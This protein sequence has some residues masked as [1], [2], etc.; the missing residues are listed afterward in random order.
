MLKAILGFL[1]LATL[2][3]CLVLPVLHFQGRLDNQSYKNYLLAAS[4]A[5]FVF[6]IPWVA[7]ANTKQRP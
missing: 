7:Q 1:S 2:A 3:A 5:W 6:A 4:V